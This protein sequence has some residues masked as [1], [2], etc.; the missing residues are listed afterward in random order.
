MKEYKIIFDNGVVETIKAGSIEYNSHIGRIE[1]ND[2]DGEE[3]EEIYIDF[4]QIT[5]IIPQ[6]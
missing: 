4:E 2:E 5:A 6:D 3:M 1:I